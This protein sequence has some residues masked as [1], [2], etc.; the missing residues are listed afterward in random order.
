MNAAAMAAAA[1]PEPVEEI[2]AVP[3]VLKH[4]LA[5]IA[6]SHEVVGGTRILEALRTGHASH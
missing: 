6:P 5:A 3:V 4:R 1:L 2:E